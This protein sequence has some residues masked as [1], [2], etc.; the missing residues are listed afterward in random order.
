MPFYFYSATQ[1][2]LACFS[3]SGALMDM[4]IRKQAIELTEYR[5]ARYSHPPDGACL[6]PLGYAFDGAPLRRRRGRGVFSLVGG[7]PFCSLILCQCRREKYFILFVVSLPCLPFKMPPDTSW[8]L[9]LTTF[10]LESRFFF[11]CSSH[12]INWW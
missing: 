11:S 10:H 9:S 12:D 6:R 2:I 5:R 7:R 3:F 1:N 8:A 4:V